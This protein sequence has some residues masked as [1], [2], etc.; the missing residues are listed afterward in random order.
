MQGLHRVRLTALSEIPPYQNF[1][2]LTSCI[3]ATIADQLRMKL[4]VRYR[5]FALQRMQVLQHQQKQ[6][7]NRI[8]PKYSS[9]SLGTHDF[10]LTFSPTKNP[11]F[12]PDQ[13]KSIPCL[14]D[15][16]VSL[17]S[18]DSILNLSFGRDERIIMLFLCQ[19]K[20]AFQQF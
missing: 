15:C 20:S 6:P 2:L 16:P 7:R 1:Y 8:K 18:F 19:C 13:H 3:N 9:T 14:L 11:Q 5:K 17:R 12:K 10:K 4:V